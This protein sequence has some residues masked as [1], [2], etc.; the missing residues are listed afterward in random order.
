MSIIQSGEF[1]SPLTQR[2]SKHFGDRVKL[3]GGR[4]GVVDLMISRRQDIFNI[5]QWL[6]HWTVKR[7]W[8]DYKNRHEVHY[9]IPETGLRI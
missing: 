3:N 4:K 1:R 7:I 5:S 2:V 8:F 9:C 6:G